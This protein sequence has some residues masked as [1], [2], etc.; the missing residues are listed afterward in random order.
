MAMVR[1]PAA[2]AD[3]VAATRSGLRPDCEITMNSAWRSIKGVRNAVITEGALAETGRRSRVST[4]YLRKTPACPEL[5]RPH[6][7]HRG[8]EP[9]PTRRAMSRVARRLR[10][11]LATTSALSPISLAIADVV[12]AQSPPSRLA[13]R[14]CPRDTGHR[15]LAS[16]ANTRRRLPSQSFQNVLGIGLVDTQRQKDCRLDVSLGLLKRAAACD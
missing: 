3:L 9:I 12:T 16:S 6:T 15:S 2:R 10:T 13:R 4:R 1:A 5:P 14:C 11:I 7:T 8:A